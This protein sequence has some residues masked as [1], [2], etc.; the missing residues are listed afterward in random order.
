MDANEPRA[1]ADALEPMA[2]APRFDGID[3]PAL[4]DYLRAQA[5]AQPV[6]AVPVDWTERL[7][8]AVKQIGYANV[9][10]WYR[11]GGEDMIEQAKSDA[12][13]AYATLCEALE[14][15]YAAPA[16][17]QAEPKRDWSAIDAAIR[18]YLD[19]YEQIGEN[20]AGADACYTPTERERDLIYD[21]INGLFADESFVAAISAPQT[22]PKREPLPDHEIVTMYAECPRSDAEMIDFA[23]AVERAHGIGGS[24]EHQ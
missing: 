20:D 21:A 5:D 19:G 6:A 24:D 18:E 13:T 12:V 14:S 10:K 15:L 22:E 11:L 8:E 16:A 1:L 2:Q 17:P 7:K 9:E 23:R 4:C 3:I